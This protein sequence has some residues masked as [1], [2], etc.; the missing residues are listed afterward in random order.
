VLITECCSSGCENG[1]KTGIKTH[2]VS[3]KPRYNPVGFENRRSPPVSIRGLEFPFIIIPGCERKVGQEERGAVC[4]TLSTSIN[5]RRPWAHGWTNSDINPQPPL[6]T[7]GTLR[8]VTR[9]IGWSMERGPLCAQVPLIGESMGKDPVAIRS[10]LLYP[11][12]SGVTL[13]RRV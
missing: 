10:L 9:M 8:L 7:A 5:N 4:A 11:R 12:E 6:G 2:P 13:R 3:A 1:C